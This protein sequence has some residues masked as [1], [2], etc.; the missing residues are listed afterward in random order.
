MKLISFISPYRPGAPKTLGGI[1][2]SFRIPTKD[3]FTKAWHEAAAREIPRAVA[4]F[5]KIK[6]E[7]NNI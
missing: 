4:L 5:T 7:K 2:S 3:D 1:K 6:S